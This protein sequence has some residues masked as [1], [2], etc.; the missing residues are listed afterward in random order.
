MAIVETKIVSRPDPS[1]PF[2]NHI[3]APIVLAFKAELGLVKTISDTDTYYKNINDSESIVVE[4]TY[5]INS[6][7]QTTRMTFDSL[8]TW[9]TVD[10]AT[11][12]ALDKAYI[13]YAEANELTHTTGQYSLAGID[14]PFTCTTTYNYNSN[15][16]TGYPLFEGFIDV[17]ESSD[18][19]TGFTNTGTQLIAV[20]TYTNATD[21]TENN[22]NDYDFITS[23]HNG[24]V[25]RTISYA[26]VSNDA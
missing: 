14:A 23:L 15:T 20:H 16:T 6:L 9:S 24:G 8:T 22:W 11:S 10:S 19:L 13:D 26:L 25:T 1:I 5:S 4:R 18:K 7:T 3:N 12:I 2:F 17:I 21:F